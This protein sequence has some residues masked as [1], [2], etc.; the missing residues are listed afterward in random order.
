LSFIQ[1]GTSWAP[2]LAA[3]L[4]DGTR[5]CFVTPTANEIV[6]GIR[7]Q[8]IRIKPTPLTKLTFFD[9]NI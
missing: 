4:P 6:F 8:D 3:D 9:A 7:N 2:D 1:G 5:L